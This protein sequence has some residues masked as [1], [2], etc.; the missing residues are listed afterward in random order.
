MSTQARYYT[1]KDDDGDTVNFRYITRTCHC[2][3]CCYEDTLELQ[4]NDGDWVGQNIESS[5]AKY[6]L[7]MLIEGSSEFKNEERLP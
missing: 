4:D 5:D 3:G 7:R 6:L 2:G 1:I